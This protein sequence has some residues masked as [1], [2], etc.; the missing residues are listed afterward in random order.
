MTWDI[1]YACPL[2]CTHCYSESGRRPSRQLAHDEMLRVADAIVALGPE[3]VEFA[4][5]EPL[6]VRG[7]FEVAGRLRSAG[8]TVNLYTGGWTLTRPMAEAATEVFSRI[9]VSVDGATAEVH[10]RIRG[11][12]GSYERAMRALALLEELAP[13]REVTFG[14]DCV[15]MRGNLHQLDE[16][17]AAVAP[18]FPS[19]GF[20]IFG[21]VIPSG[22]ASRPGFEDELL[23]Q[24]ELRTLTDP[25]YVARLRALAPPT[26]QVMT[27]DNFM[28]QMN[29][30]FIER[31]GFPMA[32]VEPDG[33]MRAMPIYE[34]T[35]GSLL[36]EDPL[37][38]WERA[39]ARWRDPFVVEAL[40]SIRSMRDW[41][42]ATR[43]IDLH[44]GSGEV[45]DRIRRRPA[46]LAVAPA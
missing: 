11:R 12:A 30:G 34:G 2:R 16:F 43:R 21:A 20:L 29:P 23:T 36:E 10:D 37:V 13:A 8:I 32:Q 6:L 42:E 1:T 35:V 45:A 38:L 3:S 27:T 14:I 28:L 31:Y 33:E 18:R 15:A 26:V 25:E 24:D 46:Y 41:A 39:I 44:F 4:G 5:G 22:L 17:C 7:I 40:S 19:L 9:T